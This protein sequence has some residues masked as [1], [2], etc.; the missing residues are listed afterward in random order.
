MRLS[1]ISKE[2]EEDVDDSEFVHLLERIK[3]EC[4]DIFNLYKTSGKCFY[5][6]RRSQAANGP[7]W[8]ERAT[9]TNRKPKDSEDYYHDILNLILAKAGM[10]AN[11][12]N[13]IFVTARLQT[14]RNY[15]KVYV[16]FPKNG[17]KYT[18]TNFEDLAAYKCTE[19]LDP[20]M[21]Q[22]IGAAERGD[23]MMTQHRSANDILDELIQ[24]VSPRDDAI[25][26]VIK[27]D[28]EVMITGT[29]IA[30]DIKVA[31]KII[32]Y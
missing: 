20:L 11:R 15:G 3:S 10:V 29:F 24:E 1:E 5:S 16:I 7:I 19:I 4:S 2:P 8:F 14:A 30:V 28:H 26:Q 17:F 6:G 32:A 12:S 22:Y 13:S 27:T 23:A 31:E 9:R 21:R 18:W 25:E